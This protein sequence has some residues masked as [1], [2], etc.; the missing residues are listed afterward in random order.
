MLSLHDTSHGEFQRFINYCSQIERVMTVSIPTSYSCN[1]GIIG[2]KS[3]YGVASNVITTEAY[4]M[5]I[6]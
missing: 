2:G 6:H 1:A 5:K 4:L 3:N